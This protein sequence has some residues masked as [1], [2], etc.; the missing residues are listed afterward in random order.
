MGLNVSVIRRKDLVCP[1][2]GEVVSTVSVD[3]VDSSGRLWY[4]F[5]E[6]IGYYVPYDK[7]TEENDWYGKN[8]K[9]TETQVNGLYKF[10]K[11]H[12]LHGSD[13]IIALIVLARFEGQDVIINADW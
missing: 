2:C 11:E 10:V 3:D 8:M 7:R 13:E 4:P 9:L 12:D 1:K 5:L 6:S